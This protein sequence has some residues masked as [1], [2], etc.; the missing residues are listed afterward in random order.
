MSGSD[1]NDGDQDNS[2]NS[3]A[4]SSDGSGSNSESGSSDHIQGLQVGCL[5]VGGVPM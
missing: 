3:T 1:M 2:N 5:P 4:H